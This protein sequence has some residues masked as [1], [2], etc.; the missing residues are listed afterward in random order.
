MKIRIDENGS[1]E[2]NRGGFWRPQF[3]PF[4]H[5][6]AWCGGWCPLFGELVVGYIPKPEDCCPPA[7]DSDTLTIC[8]G[9]VLTGEIIDERKSG[10]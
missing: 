2:I 3:G 5:P 7:K 10:S 4:A 6:E 9:R 1:I 8:Q